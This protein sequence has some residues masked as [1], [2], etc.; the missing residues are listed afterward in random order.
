[1]PHQLQAG[2]DAIQ[3]EFTRP[4]FDPQ[5]KHT[6]LRGTRHVK[7]LDYTHRVHLPS[8]RMVDDYRK[9]AMEGGPTKADLEKE[10]RHFFRFGLMMDLEQNIKLTKHIQVRRYKNLIEVIVDGQKV[11]EKELHVLSHFLSKRDGRLYAARGRDLKF[12]LDIGK[13]TT[14]S[15]VSGRILREQQHNHVQHF[16]LRPHHHTSGHPIGGSLAHSSLYKKH[17]GGKIRLEDVGEGLRKSGRTTGR[18]MTIAGAM[19]LAGLPAVA[20][21]AP[22]AAP[23]YAALAGSVGAAGLIM[24]KGLA[25]HPDLTTLSL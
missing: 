24:H 5:D 11:R 4:E 17:I 13:D 10:S 21:A 1:M 19:G 12:I 18:V 6:V 3:H 22:G 9:I 8:L 20:I 25:K 16:V 15:M 7:H 14:D 23:L 2:L